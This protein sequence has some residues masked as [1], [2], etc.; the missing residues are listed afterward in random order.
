M[1][2]TKPKPV[3]KPTPVPKAKPRPKRNPIKHGTNAGYRQGC[4]KKCCVAAH[5]EQAREYR[6]RKQAA[7]VNT[8]P[9]RKPAAK[10]SSQA[11]KSTKAMTVAQAADSG[12]R[13]DLLIAMRSRIATTVDDSKTPA[14]DLAALSRRLQEIG[15][16]LEAL[17]AEEGQESEDGDVE[18]TKFDP[19]S[20]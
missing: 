19:A 6:A 9:K 12:S 3:P 10:A 11:F 2:P 8:A 20:I 15:K 18:D 17:D 1:S 13:R 14:R 7:A 16:E 5:A 4:R